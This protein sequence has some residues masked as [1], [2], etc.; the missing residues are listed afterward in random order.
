[1]N[2]N[3]NHNFAIQFEN[4][5]PNLIGRDQCAQ[6]ECIL[7]MPYELKVTPWIKQSYAIYADY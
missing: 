2:V 3:D 7:L 1:M 6:N 5:I 4:V